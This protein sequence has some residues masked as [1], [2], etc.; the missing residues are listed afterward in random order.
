MNA[1]NVIADLQKVA[2]KKKAVG[3]L[4]F[5]KT[6]PGQYGEGDIFIG[7]T[8]PQQ[9]DIAKKYISLPL[10]EISTLLQNKIHD[11]RSV[12]LQILVLQFDK[13]QTQTEKSAIVE[14]YLKHRVFVNN[15]DLV[16]GTAR[17]ILGN[18]LLD[19]PTEQSQVLYD[20]ARSKILWERRIAIVAT[21]AFIWNHRFEH[22]LKISTILLLDDE[23]L[24][25][26]ATGWM[27]REMGKKDEKPL[28]AFL[29]VYSKKMPRTM[30]RYSLERLD[31]KSKKKYMER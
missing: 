15:W 28:R 10:S 25:H 19:K 22:T 9:R 5:F 2:N 8:T 20:F 4:R 27:L 31:V 16:D 14:F 18:W 1:Q 29:D 24:M 17:Q 6:G 13:S 7:T 12:A 3:N 21:Q 30:L 11:Y 26:K 23:D